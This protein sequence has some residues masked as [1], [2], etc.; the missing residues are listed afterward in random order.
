MWV[1]YFVYLLLILALGLVFGE[2]LYNVT[3]KS[4]SSIEQVGEN[5]W[6][7]N[8]KYIDHSSNDLID[9]MK[10]EAEDRGH[11]QNY[12]RQKLSRDREVI[13]DEWFAFNDF[14]RKYPEDLPVIPKE[15][16]DIPH[17]RYEQYKK[18]CDKLESAPM[19]LT[20]EQFLQKER[21][22]N[23]LIYGFPRLTLLKPFYG[24]TIYHLETAK[25][26]DCDMKEAIANEFKEKW[27]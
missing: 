14:E 26:H 5:Q 8:G 3:H 20:K 23:A 10:Q 18:M 15:D 22:K 6:I 1:Q 24:Y 13:S 9:K 21:C 12:E 4:K 19:C 7:I 17:K 11:Y 27:Y 16:L 25:Y 2:I